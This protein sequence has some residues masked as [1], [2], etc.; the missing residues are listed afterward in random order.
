MVNHQYKSDKEKFNTSLD[1][2]EEIKPNEQGTYEGDCEQ[3]CRTLKNI[4][5]QFKDW[6]YYYCT[7]DGVGH[8]V[9]I[10]NN[11]IID[12]NCQM[13]M[14]LDK[15]K[16]IYNI[17]GIKKINWFTV[18]SKFLFGKLFLLFKGKWYGLFNHSRSCKNS[19][20]NSKQ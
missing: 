17:S 5:K 12:C 19:S 16:E 20:K 3:Y 10:K 15:Y 1:I 8:Y 7:L 14:T 4:D 18:F 9:L 11:S 6:N 13:I 2:W